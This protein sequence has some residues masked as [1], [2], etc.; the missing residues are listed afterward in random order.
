MDVERFFVNC[1]AI[2][3]FAF[4]GTLVSTAAIGLLVWAA[5]ALGLCAPFS[6]LETLLFGSIISATDPVRNPIPQGCCVGARCACPAACQAVTDTARP[7]L[8]PLLRCCTQRRLAPSSS[9]WRLL[10]TCCCLHP[11]AI[12]SKH[13]DSH[14]RVL[15]SLLTP[16]L[17]L[18]APPCQVT[19]LSV[20]TRLG[21][22]PDLFALVLGE[23]LM[24]DAVAMVSVQWGAAWAGQRAAEVG[25]SRGQ[26][27]ALEASR[28][29]ACCCSCRSA[30]LPSLPPCALAGAFQVPLRLPAHALVCWR[31]GSVCSHI[32]WHLCGIHGGEAAW[33][34]AGCCCM[35]GNGAAAGPSEQAG[36]LNAVLPCIDLLDLT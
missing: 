2:A 15:L 13:E 12:P 26:R 28:L 4:L 5:G 24:N 19:V 32:H 27:Q 18:P 14:A 7:C 30:V 1:G 36:C 11:G 16:C 22:D 33:G 29:C 3:C 31:R 23:S 9:T 6:F 17:C 20:F 34:A 21:A 8:L 10:P 35:L 25:R